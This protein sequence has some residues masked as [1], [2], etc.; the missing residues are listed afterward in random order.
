MSMV[1]RE[2]SW[3]H[4]ED[5]ILADV[6]LEMAQIESVS[7]EQAFEEASKRIGTRTP[8]A[9]HTRWYIIKPKLVAFYEKQ[10]EFEQ[11]TKP[12]ESDPEDYIDMLIN[13]TL[14]RKDKPSLVGVYLEE[15]VA[16]I[17]DLLGKRGGRGAKSR[18]VNE[19]LRKLFIS[20]GLL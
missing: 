20:K 14:K 15:Q 5:Q 16:E 11:K 6:M 2:D 4:K 1:Y 18:I 12:V 19:C 17:L 7:M 3:T 13:D 10:E 9:C 8:K